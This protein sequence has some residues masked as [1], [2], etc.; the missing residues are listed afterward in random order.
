MIQGQGNYH[1]MTHSKKYSQRQ[2][3][4][5]LKWAHILFPK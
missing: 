5:D 1:Y 3:K 4:S 2:L